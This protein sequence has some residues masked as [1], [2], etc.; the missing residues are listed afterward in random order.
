ME[1]IGSILT[2]KEKGSLLETSGFVT[3]IKA[4]INNSCIVLTRRDSNVGGAGTDCRYDSW[5]MF[6]RARRKP[7]I[8]SAFEE[9]NSLR[10]GDHKRKLCSS[11]PS[12]P[13]PQR[14]KSADLRR[15]KEKMNS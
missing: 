13:S 14:T 3:A 8:I 4:E 12:S 7:K 10:F 2:T 5:H 1:A 9:E 6:F 15:K 11:S